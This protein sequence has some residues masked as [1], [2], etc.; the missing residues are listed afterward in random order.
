MA[1]LDRFSLAGKVALVT[2]GAGLYGTQ[3]VRAL[4][5]A[6]AQTYIA[7]RHLEA[8]ETLAAAYRDRGLD[9]TALQVDQAD[10]ASILA[11]RDRLFQRCGQ[12][13]ILVNNAVSRPMKQGYQDSA[14]TFAE[15]M[16]VNATGLFLLTRAFGDVMAEQGSGSIINIGSIQG[17]IGPDPTIYEGTEMRGWYPDY[18]FH[19][20]G[21][22]NFTRFVASYY[23]ARGI[24]CNCI[25]PGGL[26]TEE[27]PLRFVRQYSART[28]LGR[29][30]NDTDLMGVIVF[31]ASDASLYV[32]GTNIPVDG[33]YTAK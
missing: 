7:S 17:M 30:A 25:S 9:V 21:M 19:K 26:R 5:E 20:G 16:Q 1:I 3:I 15:S 11:L 23:G 6:G 18:F 12:V 13:D 29:M 32:T 8:L 14:S 2:G 28:F 33:G 31:L 10:E 4:A 22:L 27:T 24:R